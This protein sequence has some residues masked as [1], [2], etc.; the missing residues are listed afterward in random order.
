MQVSNSEQVFRSRRSLE[1][2]SPFDTATARHFTIRPA[3]TVFFTGAV[4]V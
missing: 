1:I 2:L 4:T 3:A